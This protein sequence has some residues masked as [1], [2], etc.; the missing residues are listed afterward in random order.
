MVHIQIC[1]TL[2]KHVLSVVECIMLYNT[3]LIAH[4]IIQYVVL[5]VHIYYYTCDDYFDMLRCPIY[6]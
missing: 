3:M 5:L 1:R 2:I 6:I 4:L